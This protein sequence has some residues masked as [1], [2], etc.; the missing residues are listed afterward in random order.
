[1]FPGPGAAQALG[2]RGRAD[3]ASSGTASEATAPPV[4]PP[5]QGGIVLHEPSG[6]VLHN[7]SIDSAESQA[8]QQEDLSAFR[9]ACALVQGV[10]ERCERA[11]EA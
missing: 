10:G 2:A 6:T 11:C 9:A 8:Q 7:N 5:G 4:P 1:M 3:T